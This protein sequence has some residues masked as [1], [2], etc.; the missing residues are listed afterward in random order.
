MVVI[1][2]AENLIACDVFK[3]TRNL[4]LT[5]T[6]FK[7]LAGVRLDWLEILFEKSYTEMENNNYFPSQLEWKILK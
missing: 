2:V 5:C 4:T 7:L 6:V 1:N 3:W